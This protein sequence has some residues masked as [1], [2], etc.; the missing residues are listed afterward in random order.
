MNPIYS[1]R[2]DGMRALITGATGH[3]GRAMAQAVAQVGAEV[4]INGRSPQKVDELVEE[5]RAEDL[6]AEPAVFDVTSPGQIDRFFKRAGWR[7]AHRPD[8]QCL[9]RRRGKH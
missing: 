5:L 1:H 2:L 9:F 8:Q 7:A 6:L 4:L 3:L